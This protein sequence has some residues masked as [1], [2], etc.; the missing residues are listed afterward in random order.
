MNK[1]VQIA[2]L[3]ILALFILIIMIIL[4][5]NKDNIFFSIF[6]SNNKVVLEKEFNNS[7]N[8]L[9]ITSESSDI[10][11]KKNEADTIKVIVYGNK[12]DEVTAEIKED[13][14]YIEHDNKI[15]FCMFFCYKRN[16][17]EISLPEKEY[18]DFKLKTTSGNINI[19]DILFKDIIASS[20]SGNIKLDETTKADLYTLSGDIHFEK[21]DM[22]DLKTT[23]G[24]IKG[25]VVSEMK[26]K[27]MSGDLKIDTINN[28]CQINTTSG[29]IRINTLNISNDSFIKSLSGDV[30]ILNTNDIYIDASTLSGSV[31]IHSNNRHAENELKITTTSGNIFIEKRGQ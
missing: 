18:N 13:Y 23:L 16:K 26:I 31:N 5:I 22:A 27:T 28:M 17:I 3:S 15:N 14:L 20:T 29:N 2:I 30:R 10:I 8:N 12:N 11:I 21:I 1:K 7:I 25:N 4:I 9:N 6:N 19:K 24:N